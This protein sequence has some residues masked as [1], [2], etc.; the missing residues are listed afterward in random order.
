ML[1]CDHA[2]R[3]ITTSEPRTSFRQVRTGYAADHVGEQ[4]LCAARAPIG[5]ALRGSRHVAVPT[6]ALPTRPP[7]A[8]MMPQR[9]TITS[10]VRAA[11]RGAAIRH[12]PS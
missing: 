6:R 12:G 5:R 11:R 7:G 3:L 4:V 1:N 9:A 8:R 2:E 10:Q